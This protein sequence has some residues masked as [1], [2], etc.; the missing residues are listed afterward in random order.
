MTAQHHISLQDFKI[1]NDL[2]F[3]LL[4]GPCQLECRDH[5]FD[6]AG[7]LQEMAKKLVT[8]SPSKRAASA[9]K[10]SF[11]QPRIR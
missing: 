4:A 5:A 10:K 6:M 11:M 3:V 9:T 8:A 1:G 2:P 7:A